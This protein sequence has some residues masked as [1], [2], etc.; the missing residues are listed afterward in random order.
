MEHSEHQIVSHEC[1]V[2]QFKP[3]VY[4]VTPTRS[5]CDLPPR[6][7]VINKPTL[8]R[9]KS[10]NSQNLTVAEFVPVPD[11]APVRTAAK[12]QEENYGSLRYPVAGIDL[13]YVL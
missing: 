3:S 2:V 9:S 8:N 7:S 4:N 11:A 13:N 6:L 5:N 10:T 12:D 1:T